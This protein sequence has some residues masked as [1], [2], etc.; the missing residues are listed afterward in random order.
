[1]RASTCDL[2]AGQL[3]KPYSRAM[4]SCAVARVGRSET[5][6]ILAVASASPARAALSRSFA[7]RRN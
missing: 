2:R 6:W 4:A 1:M 3:E 5:A 7:L